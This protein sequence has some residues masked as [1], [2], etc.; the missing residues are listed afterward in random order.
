VSLGRLL[1]A[2]PGGPESERLYA[3]LVVQARRPGFYEACG[4]PDTVDGR[5]DMIAL[6]AFLVLRRLKRDHPATAGLA[7][8]VFDA[9]FADMDGNLREMGV[10]D[11]GVAHRIKDMVKAFYGRIAAYEAGLLGDDGL[12]GHALARNLYRGAGPAADHLARMVSYMRG[13][14]RALADQPTD[15]LLAGRVAFGPA[16]GE[17]EEALR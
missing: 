1:G 2:R 9:L 16:P 8:G 7:Q 11:L 13:Q 3:A 10:G 17:D 4:V 15:G 5:F 12:L 6:H 14:D